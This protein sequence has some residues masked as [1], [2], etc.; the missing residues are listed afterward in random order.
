MSPNG[1]KSFSNLMT[2]AGM[3][4][5]H[6]PFIWLSGSFPG[7]ARNEGNDSALPVGPK[8]EAEP[9]NGRSQAGAWERELIYLKMKQLG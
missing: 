4:R 5:G 2:K 1:T 9:P 8:L 7:S 3:P 6:M